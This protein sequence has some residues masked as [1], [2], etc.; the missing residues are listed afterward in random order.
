MKKKAIKK[1][2]LS[3]IKIASLNAAFQAKVQGGRKT[4]D[5]TDL[6][7]DGTNDTAETFCVF[8][9]GTRRNC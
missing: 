5:D 6:T 8:C 7:I 2:S 3:K 1:L 9:V 4:T